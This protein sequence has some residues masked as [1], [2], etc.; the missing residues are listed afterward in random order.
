MKSFRQASGSLA[1]I[2]FTEGADW[3]DSSVFILALLL[4]FQE[5]EIFHLKGVPE[6]T[7]QT[8]SKPQETLEE[9]L[10]GPYESFKNHLGIEYSFA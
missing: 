8:D 3:I 7:V 9:M 1:A 4:H 2:G 6:S 5:D 10:N